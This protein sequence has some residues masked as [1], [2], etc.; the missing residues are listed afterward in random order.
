MLEALEALPPNCRPYDLRHSFGDELYRVTGDLGAV[1]EILQHASLET[2]KRY[3]ARAV[4][5]RVATA[6]A[7][8]SEANAPAAAP[9]PTPAQQRLRLVKGKTAKA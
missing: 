4:S 1:G 9:P 7:K 3:T 8:M 2:T 6:F 5:G